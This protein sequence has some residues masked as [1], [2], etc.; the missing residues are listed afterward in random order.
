MPDLDDLVKLA[1]LGTS[2]ICIFGIFWTGWL[3]KT[4]S[5]SEN[6][7]FHDS[8]H[9]YMKLVISVAVIS[10]ISGVAN[11]YIKQN[12]INVLEQQN[13]ALEKERNELV[14]EREV[15]VTKTQGAKNT[16]AII[17]KSK[18]AYQLRNPNDTELKSHV[19]QLKDYLDI[20]E[21]NL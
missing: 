7:L 9:K 13:I 4:S 3:I 17:L 18:E 15:L 8:L 20:Q 10:G 5:N 2:G 1:S 12:E 14:I 19:D 11:A 16:L 21:V 6:T